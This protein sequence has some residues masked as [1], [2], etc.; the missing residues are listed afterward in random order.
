MEG[1]TLRLALAAAAAIGLGAASAL[2]VPG[3][4][5]AAAASQRRV[6]GARRLL[7][8]RARHPPDS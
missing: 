4:A 5:F 3:Q 6:R 2:V 1:R 7:H 8:V